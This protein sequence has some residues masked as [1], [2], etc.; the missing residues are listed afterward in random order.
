M[1]HKGM[2]R[3]LEVLT[4]APR[5][6]RKA[7]TEWLLGEHS[8]AMRALPGLKDLRIY[9]SHEQSIFGP[10]FCDCFVECYFQDR[11]ALEEAAK[12]D[13][14]RSHLEELGRRGFK[15][16]ENLQVVWA[17]ENIIDIPNG[18]RKIHDDTGKFCQMGTLRCAPGMSVADLKKWWLEEHAET[19]KH[20]LGLKWYTVLM[21]MKDAPWGL[22]PFDGYA[23]VWY[24]TVAECKAA[25]ASE[26]MQGQMEDV[27]R[28]NMDSPELSKV[29]LADEHIIGVER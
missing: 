26:I 15:S 3:H 28:H 24:D 16:G 8:F 9:V 12:S 13:A 23:S 2:C 22:P 21:T 4:C 1:Y 6:G 17:E 20:L 11:R 7:V 10:P 25:A 29:V 5:T 27:R 19:G 14:M 18:P